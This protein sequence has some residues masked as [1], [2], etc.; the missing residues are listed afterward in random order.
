MRNSGEILNIAAAISSTQIFTLLLA[1]GSSLSDVDAI[2]LHYA[3]GSAPQSRRGSP[4][5]NR[6]PMME[7]LVDELGMDV[8]AQD[9][10]IMIAPSG[11]G[12]KGTPLAYAIYWKRVEE[13]K[14]RGRSGHQVEMR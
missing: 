2:P 5:T 1:H 4:P 11:L 3:A 12:Q 8:N 13:A 6:I 14:W 7:Y 9:D 10:G